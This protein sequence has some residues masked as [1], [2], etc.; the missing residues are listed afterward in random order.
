M[1]KFWHNFLRAVGRDDLI[2]VD[3]SSTDDGAP[4]RADRI[5]RAL[6]EIFAQR[7]RAEWVELF[8]EH[9]IAGGPVNSVGDMLVDPHFRARQNTY[10]VDHDGVGEL[11]F[12]VSPVRVAGR[13]S[14]RHFRRTSAPTPEVLRTVAGY[15]D[16]QIAVAADPRVPA[17]G[18][19]VH[20]G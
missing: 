3:L 1:S 14:L 13:S 2:D 10:R 15:D 20:S 5:W 6:T 18:G 4:A 11:E 16:A 12:V 8:L 17:A 9:E 19:R 7:T